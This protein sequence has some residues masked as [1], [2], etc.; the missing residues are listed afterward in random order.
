[1][2]SEVFGSYKPATSN[3]GKMFYLNITDQNL[4]K[5]TIEV[6]LVSKTTDVTIISEPN[7]LPQ[8]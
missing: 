2:V 6:M 8:N 4:A 1:M 3:Y 5:Y 7:Q